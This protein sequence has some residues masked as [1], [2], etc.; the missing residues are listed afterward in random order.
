MA[1]TK[2]V[3]IA[4][5]FG[6]RYGTVIRAKIRK[7]EEFRQVNYKCPKCQTKAVRRVCVGLWTCTKCGA[8]FTGGAYISSTPQGQTSL[9]IV[10]RKEKEKEA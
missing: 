8:T 3:G 9:R 2:K 10:K 6:P 7:L 4:G 5:R 1:H